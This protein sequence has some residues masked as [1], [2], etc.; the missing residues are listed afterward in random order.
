MMSVG[1]KN[2]LF[3]IQSLG[4]GGAEKLLINL[5]NNFDRNQ[6]FIN[7]IALNDNIA[8]VGEI[9]SND[10]R[11]TPLPRKWRYDMGPARQI[12]RI[13]I[14]N[15]IDTVIAFDLF[16][17]F[18]VR[19]ALLRIPLKPRIFISLHSTV[20]KNLKQ[21]LQGMIYA[22]LLS[23]KESFISVCDAQAD[24]LSKVFWIPRKRFTT[25]YN[26]VD[27]EYFHPSNNSYTRKSIRS[28][29]M[30]PENGFV[31]LQVASLAP[32]KRHEDTLA[33]LKNL[34]E[35][36]PGLPC[37]LLFVGQGSKDREHK[38]QVLAESLTISNRVRFCGLQSDVRPFYQAADLF[39][40]SSQFIETFSVAALE[41]M[42]MG[43]PCVLTDVS[44]ACEMIVEGT[45]GYLVPPRKPHDL[46]NAWLKVFKNKDNFNHE[47]IRAWV[48]KHFTLSDCIRYYEDILR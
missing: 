12:R 13:I 40:L 27:V 6:F 30:I 7:V 29:L 44:G 36:S 43:L 33:A 47:K 38:L 5:V 15:Q 19:H 25:I 10:T 2:I 26:G 14:E 9:H 18:Y 46:A 39:T 32:H 11:F 45:N 24:Y 21:V 22:R 35:L 23:G 8:L 1:R 48:I 34:T 4:M 28:S 17:F 37:Y 20:Q 3:L 41:A 42:S 16:S 31:I